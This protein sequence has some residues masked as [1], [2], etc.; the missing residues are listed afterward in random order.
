MG[1]NFWPYISKHHRSSKTSIRPE[2]E[3][4]DE[5]IWQRK[6]QASFPET[7]ATSQRKNL[8]FVPHPREI[9]PE[10]RSKPL[11]EANYHLE[12]F[13]PWHVP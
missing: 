13:L 11:P 2:A 4:L 9:L 10:E 6:Y 5:I 1:R 8:R 3:P 12:K 7:R